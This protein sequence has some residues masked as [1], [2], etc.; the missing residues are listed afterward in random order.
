MNQTITY[1]E[2][3]DLLCAC[4]AKGILPQDKKV[5]MKDADY[6]V[7]NPME[8]HILDMALRDAELND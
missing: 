2:A 5:I 3:L 7:K 4:A 1:I 6:L 8:R